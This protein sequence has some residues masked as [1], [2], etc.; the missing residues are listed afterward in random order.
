[1]DNPANT[2]QTLAK[3]PVNLAQVADA[4]ENVPIKVILCLIDWLIAIITVWLESQKYGLFMVVINKFAMGNRWLLV[5]S[6]YYEFDLWQDTINPLGLRA[7]TSAY[8]KW[9]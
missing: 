7:D 4:L 9:W 5:Y 3:K 1:M 2:L 6:K 8:V